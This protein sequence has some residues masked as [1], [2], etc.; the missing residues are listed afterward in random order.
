MD[1]PK[2]LW[3]VKSQSVPRVRRRSMVDLKIKKKK[4][5][6]KKKMRMN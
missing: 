6:K 1:Q 3:R 2:K 4:K 5:K